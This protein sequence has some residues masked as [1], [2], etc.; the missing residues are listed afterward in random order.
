MA[1]LKH[2]FSSYIDYRQILRQQLF[3]IIRIC[4][5][6]IRRLSVRE[7][8]NLKYLK[9][10]TDIEKVTNFSIK[11][12]LKQKKSPIVL[13]SFSSGWQD[14]NLRPPHPKCGAIPGYATPR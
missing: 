14:S 12:M 7:N 3:I 6:G 5:D 13:D 4:N 1:Y 8:S 11:V 2:F 10:E 9:E